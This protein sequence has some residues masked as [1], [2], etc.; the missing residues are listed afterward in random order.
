M[1]YPKIPLSYTRRASQS[2]NHTYMENKNKVFEVKH[3]QEN[4]KMLKKELKL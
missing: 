2:M 1:K 3:L 4:I